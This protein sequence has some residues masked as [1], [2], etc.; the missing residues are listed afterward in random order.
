MK[1]ILPIYVLG[2]LFF[3][4]SVQ[5]QKSYTVADETFELNIDVEGELTL[6]W[7]T[8]EGEFRYFSKKGNE[9]IELKNT[10]V[11][12][13][14]LE[15]FKDV[16]KKQTSDFPVSAEKLKF[17]LASLHNYFIAYN[18]G[19][20]SITIEDKSIALQFRLGAFAGLTNSAYTENKTNAI[21][22]IAGVEL[23]MVDNIILK[24]HALVLR[25]KQTFKNDEYHYSA[26]QFSLNYRFKFVKSPKFDVFINCKFVSLTFSEREISYFNE[27]F[28]PIFITETVS[29][30]DFNA[31]VTFGFG[32][33]Y[34]VGNGYITF[35]YD[36]IVGLN[37]KNYGEFPIDFT[38]GYK[39]IL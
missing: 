1:K 9:I 24:R 14:Y 16:L 20:D 31:P 12:G 18:S 8:F 22:P 28:P 30:T 32:A 39:F 37:I 33:D 38:L 25:F 5:A 17:N 6:L 19:R 13:E 36:D 3:V 21:R 27:S 10:Y 34:K 11:N 15:E 29:G 2:L 35:N 4:N 26:S 23:E 7:N